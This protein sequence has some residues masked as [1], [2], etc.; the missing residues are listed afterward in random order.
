M[1]SLSKSANLIGR[2]TR[3][4]YYTPAASI[5]ISSILRRES[6]VD[7]AK[8]VAE[9]VNKEVG[10]RASNV[11]EDAENATVAAAQKAQDIKHPAFKATETVNKKT[12]EKL[13]KVIEGAESVTGTAAQKA[14]DV[15]KAAGMDRQGC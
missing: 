6:V 10:K 12:G 5:H 1:N 11:I 9:T 13:S 8:N 15:K 7:K 14:Q 2:S 3:Q 4:L